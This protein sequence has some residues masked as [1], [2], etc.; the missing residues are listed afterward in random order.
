MELATR[1]RD[2]VGAGA[3]DCTRRPRRASTTI[4]LA[5]LE[6]DWTVT[7]RSRAVAGCAFD[8]GGAPRASTPTH[9]WC[10]TQGRGASLV[11]VA[12]PDRSIEA[13]ARSIA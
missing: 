1:R 7:L 10:R 5:L 12:T 6:L 8:R 2:T 3:N 13:A 11:I 4:A 9:R